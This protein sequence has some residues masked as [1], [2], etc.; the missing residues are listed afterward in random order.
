MTAS[1]N[2]EWVLQKYGSTSY[3]LVVYLID[4]FNANVSL[5]MEH[6]LLNEWKALYPSNKLQV[7][8]QVK[9]V[10][11]FGLLESKFIADALFSGGIEL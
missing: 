11:G 7:V 9:E 3:Q 8:R 4:F 6:E 1:L 2:M 5:V 10:F